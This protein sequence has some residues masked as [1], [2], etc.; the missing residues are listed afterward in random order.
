MQH[1]KTVVKSQTQLR[2][3]MLEV[4]AISSS[5]NNHFKQVIQFRYVELVMATS[6]ST[7]PSEIH[8]CSSFVCVMQ[9]A[10]NVAS[11]KHKDS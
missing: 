5:F 7:N 8:K 4:L 11:T 6:A 2:C 3:V 1:K 10:G 9:V